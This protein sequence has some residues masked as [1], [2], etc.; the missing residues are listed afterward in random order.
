MGI[1][2]FERLDSEMTNVTLRVQYRMNS[3]IMDVANK[4]TYENKLIAANETIANAT[5]KFSNESVTFNLVLNN[6][7]LHYF[8]IL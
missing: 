6:Q 1:S 7:V 2:L 8:C 3:R 4:L 5:M